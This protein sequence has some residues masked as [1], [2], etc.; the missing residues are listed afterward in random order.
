MKRREVKYMNYCQ[1]VFI[2][3]F[4]IAVEHITIKHTVITKQQ[5]SRT[6]NKD[7]RRR[8]KQSRLGTL[9]IGEHDWYTIGTYV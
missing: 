3:I 5:A 4:L 2:I 7:T 1:E 9:L 6:S 8:C